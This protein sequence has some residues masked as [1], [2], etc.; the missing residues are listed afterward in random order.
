MGVLQ[1]PLRPAPDPSAVEALDAG[2]IEEARAHQR[3]QRR[4]AALVTIAAA[5]AALLGLALAGGF[6]SP[7]Q[8]TAGSHHRPSAAASASLASCAT[9]KHT[10]KAV[11]GPPSRALLSLLGVLRRPATA[12][13]AL[14]ASVSKLLLDTGLGPA[15][16]I[17]I[18][19]VRRA[20]VIA[21]TSYWVY[22]ETI[23]FCGH[24][25]QGMALWE[26][27]GPGSGAGG[28]MGDAAS[29]A[30]G[31]VGGSSGTFGSTRVEM[32]IPDG[33]TTVTLRYPAG[34][35]GG[36]DRHHAGATTITSP[37]VGNLLIVTVP[38]GGNR[39]IAPMTMTWRAPNGATVKTFS[40][41]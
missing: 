32:L 17:F 2:V 18:N 36:F 3:L 7:R 28:G 11:Q 20:R 38:R 16:T 4:I 5:G 31:E 9:T 10:G 14:P 29:I 25:R 22:P 24:S 12:A 41:L 23:T 1:T 30:D 26:S 15:S 21:D 40:R 34:K 33:V 8:Q 39:L 35:I 37:V 13:D 27:D 6:A 19:Y